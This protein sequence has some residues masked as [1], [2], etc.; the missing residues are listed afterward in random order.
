VRQ[1]GS[2]T[3]QA[4][5]CRQPVV[6]ITPINP[7]PRQT[8][9]HGVAAECHQRGHN[10]TALPL[11]HGFAATRHT[12]RCH[13]AAAT[14]LPPRRRRTPLYGVKAASALRGGSEMQA[15]AAIS[16]VPL[17]PRR[18]CAPRAACACCAMP[19]FRNARC[20]CNHFP[21]FAERN[22]PSASR[23]DRP[24]FN[25]SRRCAH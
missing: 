3:T 24:S 22:Q 19:A 10:A 8:A 17:Q 20:A 9:P 1:E 7:P 16:R 12:L 21:R 15:A 23:R 11:R 2:E 18:F 6:L 5:R 25:M 13:A 4:V 14:R